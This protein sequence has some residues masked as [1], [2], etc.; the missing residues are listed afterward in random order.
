[1]RRKVESLIKKNLHKLG[2]EVS[3]AT[4]NYKPE[5]YNTVLTASVSVQP[6]FNIIEVGANDGKYADPIYEFVREH[7]NRTNIILIE[8][9]DELIPYLRENYSYHQSSE[10][11]NKAI[12]TRKST[13]QLYRIKKGY[14]DRIN[15][16]YGE[17]WPEYRVPTGV[18]T[19]NEKQLLDWISEHIQTE[20]KPSEVIEKYDVD[21]VQPNE[22][23]SRSQI[24]N[25]VH[26][27]QVDA[28]GLDNKIVYNFFD[29]N[30]F[31]S[32]V[33]IESKH[34]DIVRKLNSKI[35]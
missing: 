11:Y 2:I 13:I 16:N 23:I 5:L 30:I 4:P 6:S 15:V 33:N 25:K 28:E 10:V 18:T 7:Q 24:I 17:H 20:S 31:P 32:I 35:D 19:S 27:L 21:V 26:L 12:G 1:M 8:P 22:V 29:N 9:Q 34:L 3:Y 14:W